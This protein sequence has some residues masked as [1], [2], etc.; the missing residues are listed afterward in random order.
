MSKRIGIL[1][2]VVV[3]LFTI[4]CSTAIDD[5][6]VSNKPFDI[7]EFFNGSIVAWGML[8]DYSSKVNRRF[9]VEIE[10]TWLENKGT[11]AET[12]YFDDGEV[13]YRNW[14]LIK[15]EDSSY[16]GTAEDVD[17]I[18]IGI[19]KGFAFQFTYNLLLT[20]D[21]ETYNVTMDDWMYQLDEYRVMNKTSMHKFGVKVAEVTLFF[22]KNIAEQTCPATIPV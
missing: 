7:K 14:Q 6:E 3:S 21:G 19:H 16:R 17:G 12:F 22:D 9:C 15:Q 10:G 11:L 18:A 20:L 13:S 4:S 5:Y 8:Q 2:I 1:F